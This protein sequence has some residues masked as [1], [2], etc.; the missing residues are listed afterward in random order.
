MMINRFCC[1]K[2][3]RIAPCE[4][5]MAAGQNRICNGQFRNA[6]IS[7]NVFFSRS[8]R[9]IVLSL[10][11]MLSAHCFYEAS[12]ESSLVSAVEFK[13]PHLKILFRPPLRSGPTSKNFLQE[14]LPKLNVLANHLNNYLAFLIKLDKILPSTFIRIEYAPDRTLEDQVNP[15]VISACELGLNKI[16]EQV[17]EQLKKSTATD[18][19]VL[20]DNFADLLLIK[21]QLS[22]ESNTF[23]E[24]T[25]LNNISSINESL[26]PDV[27]FEIFRPDTAF[28]IRPKGNDCEVVKFSFDPKAASSSVFLTSNGRYFNRISLSRCGK[29]LAYIEAGDLKITP[30]DIASPKDV[31]E[32]GEYQLLDMQ[33]SPGRPCLAGIVLNRKSLNREIFIYDASASKHFDFFKHDRRFIGNFQYAFPYWSPC[34]TRLIFSSGN[35]VHLIDLQAERLF[36]DVFKS[37]KKTI[38]EIIWSP[39]G[40]SFALVEVD[41]HSRNKTEFDD[42]DFRNSTLRR[43]DIDSEGVVSEDPAQNYVSS[44]TIKLVSFWTLDRVLFLEGRLTDQRIISPL[45]NFENKFFAR[46]T[47]TPSLLSDGSTNV[48][49]GFTDLPMKYCYAFKLLDNNMRNIYNSGN[50][51]VNYLYQNRMENIWF[52]GLRIPDEIDNRVTTFCMRQL[53]YPFTERNT[54][55]FL[56]YPSK[57]VEH[58]LEMLKSY[59]LR[60]FEIDPV[61]G[62]IDFLSNSRGPMNLWS[63]SLEAFSSSA[64]ASVSYSEDDALDTMP[65]M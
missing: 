7:G 31:F 12:A 51:S 57:R 10:A 32:P 49:T 2:P 43:F 1:K 63:G 54:V 23:E 20:V 64:V 22:R 8:C 61:A 45:W 25:G 24:R 29:Y 15:D 17:N 35:H 28:T 30:T 60:R 21:D 9:L 4:I 38:S 58:M 48:Q 39:G 6:R 65:D 18:E 41:G 34:G 46:L 47:P 36:P 53:P 11:V 19:K 13:G 56:D 16:L 40:K 5:R 26:L 55:I 3:E 42:R 50:S 62:R 59:D 27:E 52:V 37:E 33:W 14:E 44:D